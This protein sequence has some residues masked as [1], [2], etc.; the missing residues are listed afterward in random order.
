MFQEPYWKYFKTS[1]SNVE[2]QFTPSF[3]CPTY[4]RNLYGYN[5]NNDVKLPIRCPAIWNDY[6]CHKYDLCYF[7]SI[8]KP[9]LK[10]K[11]NYFYCASWKILKVDLPDLADRP[12]DQPTASHSQSSEGDS[13]TDFVYEESNSKDFKWDG[14]SFN[15]FFRELNFSNLM[16]K[17][18]LSMLKKDPD[19]KKKCLLILRQQVLKLL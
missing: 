18:S 1:Y 15:D 4:H 11:A 7:Y 8:E 9:S 16:F 5:E 3:I 12:H 19:L 17:K 2:K 10:R 13:D 14:E 6:S